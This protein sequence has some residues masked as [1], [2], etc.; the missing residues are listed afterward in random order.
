LKNVLY[1][2]KSPY[3]WDPR[4]EKICKTLHSNNFDVNLLARWDGKQRENETI[5]GLN[6]IRV[7]YNLPTKF[8]APLFSNPVW[9]KAISSAIKEFKPT[10]IMPREI[11]LAETCGKAGRKFGIPVLMDMAE[12]YPAAM[13]G[14]DKYYRNIVKRFAVHYLNVPERVERSCVGLMDGILTVSSE[15]SK[16]LNDKYSYPFKKMQV[17]HNTPEKSW[18]DNVRIGSSVPPIE[19]AY[20]GYMTPDRNLDKMVKGF[21]IAAK[22]VPDIRLT[23][24]GTGDTYETLLEIAQKSQYTDRI[25]FTGPY[26]HSEIDKLYSEMDIGI[27]PFKNN[28]FINHIIAN[29][30]F[31]YLAA[32]KPMIVSQAKP[33]ARLIEETKAGIAV[34][35]NDENEIAQAIIKIRE[36]DVKK[37]SENGRKAFLE[38]YNWDVDAK[39]MI[40]FIN[41]II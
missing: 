1:V 10:L 34:D 23:V 15:L 3:P 21:I 18:F 28:E 37:F 35:C 30:F 12:H 41:R 40:E 8:S 5:D 14:W 2:W 24:A 39:N 13:K 26:L 4:I 33:M 6:V 27:L 17:I 7:G 32:G 22:T 36:M 19:F 16:R 31:D 20:H 25:R 29:K 11:M 38:K 9:K